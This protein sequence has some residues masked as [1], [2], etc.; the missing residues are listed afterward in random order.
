MKKVLIALGSVVV[1]AFTGCGGANG[2]QSG[3]DVTAEVSSNNSEN[4]QSSTASSNDVGSAT[5]TNVGS[6]NVADQKSLIEDSMGI[7]VPSRPAS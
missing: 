1:L 7:A 5:T 2:V 3:S 4:T 6:L